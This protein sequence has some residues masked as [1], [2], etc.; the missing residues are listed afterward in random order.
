VLLIQ[1]KWFAMDVLLAISSTFDDSHF[2][3]RLAA[4]GIRSSVR[5]WPHS[6]LFI[7]RHEKPK[8]TASWWRIVW[9]VKRHV[10]KYLDSLPDPTMNFAGTY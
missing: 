8:K 5:S 4:A 3:Q 10:S 6:F 9:R 7:L 1:L 2:I